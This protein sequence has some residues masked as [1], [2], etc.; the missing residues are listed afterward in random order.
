[1]YEE[2][3]GELS[4]I[5]TRWCL[6]E[7]FLTEA[8]IDFQA[9]QHKLAS[10]WRPGKGMYVKEP[11][12][13]RYIFQFYHEVDIARVIEGS[14]WIFGQFHL[15]FE[16]LKD[17]YDPRMI[18]INKLDLWIQLHG[19]STG[20]MSQKVVVDVGNY[21]RNFVESDS[22]NFVGVWRDYF[23]VKVTINLSKPLK[24]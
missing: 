2:S 5:D 12:R 10:L 19:M 15:V 4:D 16:R 7:R 3:C 13:N 23:R 9:M 8:A 11:E 20:F 14:P 6:V 17:G 21:I 18:S 1:M 24:E 22:N